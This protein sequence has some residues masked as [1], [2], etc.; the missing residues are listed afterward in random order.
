MSDFEYEEEVKSVFEQQR[1]K[2]IED[3][4][5]IIIAFR[6]RVAIL[7]KQLEE[8]E[9]LPVPSTVVKQMIE[10][11]Q[12]NR[13]LKEDLDYYKGLLPDYVII[14]RENKNKPTRSGGLKK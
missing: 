10:L 8:K 2:Q 1:D 6:T 13:K 5:R 4:N 7:E 12:R 3:L 9:K 11:E 14:N